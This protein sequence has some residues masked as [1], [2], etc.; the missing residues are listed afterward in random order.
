MFK[1]IK[2]SSFANNNDIYD[3]A[4]TVQAF[5]Y[6]SL[7]SKDK[8]NT[9]LLP[10]RSLNADNLLKMTKDTSY[11]IENQS[12]KVISLISDNDRINRNTFSKLFGDNKS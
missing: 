3:R 4:I 1:S 12:F 2:L 6:T 8:E 5:M 11:L 10:I 7:F 9:L